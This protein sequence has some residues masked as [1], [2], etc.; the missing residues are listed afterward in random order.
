MS[1]GKALKRIE[2]RLAQL[3]NSMAGFAVRGGPVVDPAPWWAGG[4][5]RVPRWP[6]PSPVDPAPWWGGGFGG[7]FQIRPPIG[8]IGD[9]APF[10][11]SRLNEAQLE[12]SLHT[13]HAERARLDSLENLINGQLEKLKE[14]G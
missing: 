10:D 3:E 5:W 12:A 9:P 11:I 4:G 7:H 2:E 6:I 13:I 8:P 14:Q 1:D